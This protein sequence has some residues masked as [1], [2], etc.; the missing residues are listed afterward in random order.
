V[1]GKLK[2]VRERI[3]SINSTQQIT[4]AMKMVSAAKLKKAQDAIVKIRPYALRLNKMLVNLLTNSEGD[5]NSRLGEER[6]VKKA[7]LVVVTSSRGLCGAFNS[8]IIKKAESALKNEFAP[9]VAKGDLT[10]LTI[11]KKGNDYFQSHY[12]KVPKIKEYI[13]AFENL[14]QEA[15]AVISGKLMREFENGK[16][17]LIKVAFARFKNAALQ[18]AEVEQFLPVPKIEVKEESAK[19]LKA[20]YLFEP[21]KDGLLET[22]IPSIMHTTFQRYLLDTH[23]SEHGARM[24]AMENATENAN[25]IL[26]DLKLEFNKARQ[27]AITKEL[28]EI[29]SGASALAG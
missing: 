2:E 8:N 21:N 9:L 15:T 25:E 22:L 1:S 13:N 10:I 4:S 3:N 19:R 14:E 17:D 18:Y 11:G 29:I 6:E 12:P 23:A 26:I 24:T 5:I 28:L 20:N 27:E 7:L 16:Y